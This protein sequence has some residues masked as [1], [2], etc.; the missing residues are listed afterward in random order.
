MDSSPG[1]RLDGARRRLLL[2]ASVLI[3]LAAWKLLA[4][5]VGAEII[6]PP[7]ER[8]LGR[9]LSLC[10]TARFWE[11]VGATAFRALLG[12]ALSLVPAVALGFLAG[13][14]E[15]VRI[16]LSPG[17]TVVRS[18]P[19]LAVILLAL[20]WFKSDL[21][22]V[23]TAVLM[24]FPVIYGNVVQGVRSTDPRLVEMAR[25]Y[26]VTRSSLVRNVYLPSVFP[27]LVS[28]AMTSLGLT[29]KVVVA[30]EVLSQ[31]LHAIGTGMQ[32]AKVELETADVFAWTMAALVLSA[33]TDAAFYAIMKR[34]S[35][36]GN[37]H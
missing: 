4:L 19:V 35:R 23:F 14:R 27:Y 12:F 30:A 24:A 16:F 10:L 22:P 26:E 11:A 18:T 7:P 36:Y 3:L 9:F 8:A 32:T 5:A 15:T 1:S 37:S 34:W 28:G 33:L 20:I 17:V 29:W 2:A 25:S 13:R 31:P 6:I 21:V